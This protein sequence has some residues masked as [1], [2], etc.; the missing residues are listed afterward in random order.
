MLGQTSDKIHFLDTGHS[1]CIILESD[2][3]FAMIDAA[4]DSDFPADKPHLNAHVR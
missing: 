1:D 4:E 3:R 2:G